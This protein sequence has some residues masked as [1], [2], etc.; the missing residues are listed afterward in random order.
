M[1][2]YTPRRTINGGG[3]LTLRSWKVPLRS[4]FSLKCMLSMTGLIVK[5][6]ETPPFVTCATESTKNV[7]FFIHLLVKP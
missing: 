1:T 6:I 5:L 2:F 4:Q 7:I 3:F